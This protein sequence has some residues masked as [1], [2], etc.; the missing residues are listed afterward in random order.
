MESPYG[1]DGVKRSLA[2][3]KEV[4]GCDDSAEVVKECGGA[5]ENEGSEDDNAVAVG[6]SPGKACETGRN[7]PS[8]SWLVA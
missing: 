2:P 5:V 7:H 3:A 8:S 6:V 1:C 4:I